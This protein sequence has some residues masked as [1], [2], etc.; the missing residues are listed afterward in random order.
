MET[1]KEEE[2]IEQKDSG[3]K[4]QTKKDDDDMDNIVNS[5]YKLQEIPQDKET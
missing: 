1:I 5:Y 2:E 3:L 4:E